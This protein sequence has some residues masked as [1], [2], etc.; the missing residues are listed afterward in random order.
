MNEINPY[1]IAGR[2]EV[3]KAVL[4]LVFGFV[5]LIFSV[6]SYAQMGLIESSTNGLTSSAASGVSAA[7][8]LSADRP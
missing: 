5:M 2:A 3:P 4:G 6:A 1:W 7:V 8:V